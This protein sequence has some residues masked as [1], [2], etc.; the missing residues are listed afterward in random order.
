ME[1]TFDLEEYKFNGIWILQDKRSKMS[2]PLLK[3]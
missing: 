3:Y 1:M 2:K